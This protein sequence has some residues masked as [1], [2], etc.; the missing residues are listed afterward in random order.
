MICAVTQMHFLPFV[1]LVS[2]VRVCIYLEYKYLKWSE[3]CRESCTDE[4]DVIKQI[5]TSDSKA[6]LTFPE[7]LVSLKGSSKNLTRLFLGLSIGGSLLIALIHLP[8]F[9]QQA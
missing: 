3:L 6:A 5:V 9:M 2:T 4:N 1:L 7:A 8:F